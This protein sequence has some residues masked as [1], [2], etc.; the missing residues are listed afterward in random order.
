MVDL[1]GGG[2]VAL[3]AH[4]DLRPGRQRRAE[5][6][7]LLIDLFKVVDGVAALAAR[8]VHHVQ[9]QAAALHMAQKVMPEAHALAGAL[10]QA[11]DVGADEAGPLPHRHDAQR[12]HQSGEVVV[13]D[14][15]PRRADGGDQGGL[16]H[17]GEADQAHVGDQLQFQ[18]DLDVL[19]GQARLCKF[20][21][22]AG[23]GGKM[24][25]AIAAAAALRHHHRLV[26]GQVGDDQP[27]GGVL[28]D[29]AHGHLDDK[30]GGVGAV[31]VAA[32]AVAAGLCGILALIAEIHQGGKVIVHHKDDVAA[33]AAVAA[34][35]AAGRHELFAVEADRPVA[36]LARVE[37]D[38]GDINKIG[39][40]CH[41][42]LL[43]PCRPAAPGRQSG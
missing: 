5:P 9:Q 3:V 19:A 29:G 4:H 25:V 38:G 7:Q 16:A 23:G 13:G 42:F 22:L 28:D 12:G 11:G 40:C 37:P 26:V 39:L 30:V 20:G 24:R 14:L 1:L 43:W 2:Q 10:D 21:H 33:A 32:P 15:G 18:R 41:V 34:V 36:A 35:G 6:L 27:A 17:V 8:D 31:A